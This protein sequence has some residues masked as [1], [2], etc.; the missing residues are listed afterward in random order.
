M[1]LADAAV[2][3]NRDEPAGMISLELV[4]LVMNSA[5]GAVSGVDEYSLIAAVERSLTSHVMIVDTAVGAAP[6]VVV[7]AV[8]VEERVLLAVNMR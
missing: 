2:I 5:D 7:G 8:G 1:R 6:P 3:A 4:C